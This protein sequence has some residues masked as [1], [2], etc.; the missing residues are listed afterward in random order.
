MIAELT[1]SQWDT[2]CDRNARFVFNLSLQQKDHR[3]RGNHEGGVRLLS[4]MTLP[5]DIVS[6]SI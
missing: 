4:E 2:I 6:V 3:V 1:P 5:S